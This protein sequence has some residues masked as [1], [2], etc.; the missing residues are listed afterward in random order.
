MPVPG[1]KFNLN[2][3]LRQVTG[4]VDT[5]SGSHRAGAGDDSD[6]VNPAIWIL[7]RYEFIVS[8]MNS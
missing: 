7:G 2:D 3:H 6:P 4:T 5:I 8:T 1:F